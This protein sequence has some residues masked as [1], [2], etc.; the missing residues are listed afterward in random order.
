MPWASL[1]VVDPV[2]DSALEACLGPAGSAVPTGPALAF[3]FVS[4]AHAGEAAQ[5]VDRVR[6]AL[7]DAEV[8]GCTAGGVIGGGHEFEHVPALSLLVGPVGGAEPHVAH[9]EDAALPDG[10]APPAAWHEAIGVA[11]PDVSSLVVVA[12]PFTSRA[13]ALL[14]GLDFAYPGAVTI[15]GLASGARRPGGQVLFAG[16]RAVREGAVVVAFPPSLGLAPGIAQGCR[17]VGASMRVTECEGNLVRR[18]GEGTAIDALR[19]LWEG[20]D[21]RDRDLVKTSLFLGFETDPFGDGDETW[22]VRNLLG[23][24]RDGGGLYVGASVRTGQRVR[25]HVRD[26]LTSAEDVR[27]TLDA[28]PR[29]A[30]EAALLFSCL[31]RGIHL[32]GEA[33]HDTRAFRDRFGG[34]PLG[35]FFCSGEIGPVGGGTHLH[36]YTSAFALLERRPLAT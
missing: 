2:L 28:M 19:T 13:D 21:E 15:G 27:R 5:V 18:L 17:P 14:A 16:G 4:A 36:G 3:A 1:A 12:D 32:Y 9:L 26:R 8:V 29:G 25:F 6:D 35:G 31:G 33:D 23:I 22:L 7:P 34:V 20:V 11:P 24:D 10:D 30:P